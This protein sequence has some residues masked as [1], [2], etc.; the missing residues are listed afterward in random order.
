[1]EDGF[2]PALSDWTAFYAALSAIA[3][4]LLGLLF[5]AVSLRLNLFRDAV[6]ADVRDFAVHVFGQYLALVLVGLVALFPD[7]HPAGLGLVLLAVGALGVGWSIRVAREYRR[8]NQ[9]P[10][11][12]NA[13]SLAVYAISVSSWVAFVV[14]GAV[15]LVRRDAEPLPWLAAAEVAML[16]LASAGAWVILSHARSS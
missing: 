7:L 6:V 8:L 9:T 11:S 10:Q 2:A 1:M 14:G 13:W 4:T 15:L 16:A 12:R 5:V 3:A